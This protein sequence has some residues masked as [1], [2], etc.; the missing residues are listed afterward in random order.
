[1]AKT[2]K[3]RLLFP[4][5]DQPGKTE[6]IDAPG[7]D[8]GDGGAFDAHLRHAPVA[9]DQGV[10]ERDVDEDPE[11]GDDHHRS[12]DPPA[13]EEGGEGNHRH[14]EHGALA[15]DGKVDFFE[16]PHSLGV[17]GEGKERPRR[18]NPEQPEDEAGGQGEMDALPQHAAD[19]ALIAPAGILGDEDSDVA[20]DP[21]EKGDGQIGDDAGRQGRG[22]GIDA[23]IGKEDPVGEF[24]QGRGRQAEDQR[25]ADRAGPPGSGFVRQIFKKRESCRFEAK[26]GYLPVE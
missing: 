19:L 20:A 15:E 10:I 6:D 12:G 8:R 24:H 22:D 3:R 5:E 23:V 21:A 1:M 18:K 14:M 25:Q 26:V 11:K 2:S 9:E 17:A 7:G 16:R 13:G 4:G